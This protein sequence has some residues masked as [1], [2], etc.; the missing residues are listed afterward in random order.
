V[1][2]VD[3]NVLVHAHRGDSPWHPQ[4]TRALERVAESRWAIP[5]PCVHEFLAI[6]THP[7]VFQP[8]SPIDDALRAVE[9]W[10]AVPTL[11]LL[12]ETESH[13]AT[14]AGAVRDGGITGPRVH[15]ARIAALCL[16]HAVSELWTAD[17]DFSRFP[18][19]KT[20]N[21]LVGHR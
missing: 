11:T 8:P 5:W 3:T 21:P 19:L 1:I 14:L 9:S 20:R 15:D 4:A 16:Q 7:R 18:A 17:R 2:A 10:L 12:G 6:A 13:W